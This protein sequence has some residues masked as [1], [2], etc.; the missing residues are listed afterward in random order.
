MTNMNSLLIQTYLPKFHNCI[1][2]YVL[3][4]TDTAMHHSSDTMVKHIPQEW[5]TVV[6]E[7]PIVTPVAEL[8]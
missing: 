4:L 8:S 2:C 5:T 3:L 7:G 6:L 1:Y